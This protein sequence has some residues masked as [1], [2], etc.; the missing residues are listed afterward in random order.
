MCSIIIFGQF[1]I[2]AIAMLLYSNPVSNYCHINM[3]TSCPRDGCLLGA[4]QV[5]YLG[6]TLW[7]YFGCWGWWLWWPPPP[8]E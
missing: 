4:T 6:L 8:P 1:Q 2:N 5:W 7:L 3:I